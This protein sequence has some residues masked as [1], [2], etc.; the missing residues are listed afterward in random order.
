MGTFSDN[1][2]HFLEHFS[3]KYPQYFQ[4]YSEDILNKTFS[5][6]SVIESTADSFNE[7]LKLF[8]PNKYQDTLVVFVSQEN[9]RNIFD[10]RSIENLL[11]EK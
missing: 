2:K 7:A 8:S 4:R 10:Q 9:D 3:K 1:A 5:R 11:W 6:S